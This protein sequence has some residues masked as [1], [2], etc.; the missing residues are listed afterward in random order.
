MSTTE[1]DE[2]AGALAADDGDVAPVVARALVLL[3]R[4]VVLFVDD[5]QADVLERGEHGGAGA[6]HDV[7][8][9]AAD[10]LPLIV[11]LAVGEAAVLN[12]HAVAE[13]LAEQ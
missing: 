10:A 6:D 3:V 9:A 7:D 2:R 1:D 13:R 12:R 5:D 4:G 8:V 11:P